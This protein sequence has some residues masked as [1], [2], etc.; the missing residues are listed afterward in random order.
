MLTPLVFFG[1]K[2]YEPEPGIF[3]TSSTTFTSELLASLAP[4]GDKNDLHVEIP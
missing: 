4:F 1:P 2:D 3:F